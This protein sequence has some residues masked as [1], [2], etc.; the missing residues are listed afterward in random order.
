MGL[1]PCSATVPATIFGED[2]HLSQQAYQFAG[3]FVRIYMHNGHLNLNGRLS[4]YQ[5][6]GDIKGN[7]ISSFL[8][9][10]GKFRLQT[11][12]FKY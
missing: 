2:I 7:T 1:C 4:T 11:F 10:L 5:A 6:V 3:A 9:V 12:A 8:I